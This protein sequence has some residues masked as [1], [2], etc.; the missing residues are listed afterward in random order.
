MHDGVTSFFLLLSAASSIVLAAV[1]LVRNPRRTTNIA[2]G[3]LNLNLVLWT[4]GVFSITHT[5]DPNTTVFC[6]RLTF[7]VSCFLPATF[8]LFIGFFPR[9]V[10]DGIKSLFAFYCVS[11]VVMSGLAIVPGP[12]Y[13]DDVAVSE[14]GHPLP[15]YGPVFQAFFI[16]CAFTFIVLHVN[17]FRK[18]RGASGIAR[19]QIQHVLLGI[20][21]TTLFAFLTNIMG[22]LLGVRSLE[23]YGPVFVMLMTAAFAYAMVR[24]HLMDIWVIFSTTTVYA[25]STVVVI[26]VFLSTISLVHW[27]LRS[28]SGASEVISTILAAIVIVLILEPLKERVQLLLNRTVLKRHYDVNKLLARTSR[29]AAECVVLDELLRTICEDIRNTVGA[30]VVRALLIDE[31]DN[32]TLITEYSSRGKEAGKRD[33]DYT[34]LLEYLRQHNEPL[35][36]EA[37]VHSR[38]TPERAQLAEMLA[39]L[40]AYL[41]LPL[42][43]TTGLVGVLA[44]GQKLS[45][46]IYSTDDVVAFTALATPLTTAIENARLYKKL[47]E[48]NQHRARI[49]S[50]MRGGVVAVDTEGLVTTVNAGAIEILGPIEIGQHMSAITPQVARIL[51]RTLEDGRA[52]SDYETILV[53][54][55]AERIPVVMS[56]SCLQVG[57]GDI[58]GSMVVLYNLTQVKRLEQN[59]QRAHRLSSVGTLAAGMAHEIKNPLVSIK[60]FSQLL[61]ERYDDPDF[62]N[63]FTDIVPHEVERIDSIV[64]RLLHFARPRPASFAHHNLR[65]IIEEVLVLVE[66]QMRKGNI[67]VETDFPGPEVG[68]YGDEQL[69]HQVFLNL[70]LNAIDAM[71]DMGTGAKLVIRAEYGRMVLRRNGHEPQPDAD[72]VKVSLS[73]SGVG[74]S[75]ESLERIFTPFYT[76]KDDGTGLGLAVVH[77]IVTEHGGSIYVESDPGEGSTFVITLPSARVMSGVKGD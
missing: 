36:L 54:P 32:N 43:R 55:G 29:H 69:L 77:G 6:I 9:G 39:E 70:V 22:P 61:L 26:L 13:L 52:I 16:I 14:T 58:T 51:Q 42:K 63:T 41:C 40:D 68:V 53:G 34:P 60:T 11:G 27:S 28:R 15:D 38:V 12:W 30:S 65:A 2:F 76:T 31:R 10:F 23:E 25:V 45:R 64:T 67:T 17:L 47:D 50:N 21:A 37:I 49:L 5:T 18:L 59:V 3:L 72:C 57:D 4:L 20:F 24:Y 74:I 8:Y 62:R 75:S 48:A 1:V 71:K 33:S 66:N 73:D 19:R 44:L 35:L 46:D 56:S 7:A